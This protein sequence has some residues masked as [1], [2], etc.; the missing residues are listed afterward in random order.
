MIITE[1]EEGN[2]VRVQSPLLGFDCEDASKSLNFKNL[3]NDR[4]KNQE[5]A[6]LWVRGDFDEIYNLFAKSKEMPQRREN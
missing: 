1:T 2:T 5:E 3:S 6:K 4:E